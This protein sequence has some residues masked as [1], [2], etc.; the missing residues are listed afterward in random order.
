VQHT[1]SHESQSVLAVRDDEDYI[2]LRPILTK[3]WEARKLILVGTV[4]FVVAALLANEFLGRYWSEG[5]VKIIGV[6]PTAYKGFQ[7]TFSNVSRFRAYV[8]REGVSDENTATFV[9]ELLS[10]PPEQLERYASIAKPISPKDTSKDNELEFGAVFVGMDLRFPGP[11]PDAAQ[12]RSRLFADYFADTFIYA[13]LLKWVESMGSDKLAT[14]YSI[15]LET[16]KIHR[17]IDEQK[18]RL[19]ALRSLTERFPEALRMGSSPVISV[20]VKNEVPGATK[21]DGDGVGRRRTPGEGFERFLS[22]VVQMVAAESA[23]I[24]GEIDLLK[25]QRKQKRSDLSYRFYKRA[26]AIDATTKAG[27]D[28]LKELTTLAADFSREISAS[29][30]VG[31][32]FVNEISYELEQRQYRY[33]TGFKFLSGPSLPEGRNK[34]NPLLI[35]LGAGAGGMFVMV[36]FALLTSWWRKNAKFLADDNGPTTAV[37]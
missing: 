22:P 18:M 23:I 32:E 36:V 14:A 2:D 9:E 6:S 12:L 28:Y 8:K 11:S 34:K 31:M 30:T 3:I 17:S 19:A 5:R 27:R 13:D 33:V 10:L 20:D 24:D 7:N 21:S 16:M 15:K 29:D 37:T 26:M 1:A 35:I 25:L 4:L